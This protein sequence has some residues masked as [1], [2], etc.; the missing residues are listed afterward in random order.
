MAS[1][2]TRLTHRIVDTSPWDISVIT[3][4]VL[5]FMQTMSLLHLAAL[6]ATMHQLDTPTIASCIAI[7]THHQDI[8]KL[9]THLQMVPKDILFQDIPT[10]DQVNSTVPH[11]RMVSG[12]M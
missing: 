4:D 3:W 5:L 7:P 9:C 10:V 6:K 11:M 8:P 1:T 12:K 2:P